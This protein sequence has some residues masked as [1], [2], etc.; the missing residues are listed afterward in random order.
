MEPPN[1]SPEQA[2]LR[3]RHALRSSASCTET[4]NEALQSALAVRIA[5]DPLGYGQK[6]AIAREAGA[7]AQDALSKMI[8]ELDLYKSA[9][10]RA[11]SAATAKEKDDIAALESTISQPKQLPG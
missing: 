3:V 9:R 4:C 6:I 11:E 1:I 7:A 2:E 10:V 8:T 5:D